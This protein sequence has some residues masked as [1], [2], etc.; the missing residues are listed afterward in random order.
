MNNGDKVEFVINFLSSIDFFLGQ[1]LMNL[2]CGVCSNEPPIACQDV[3]HCI[4][5]ID[6][7]VTE[8]FFY[9]FDV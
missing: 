3:V 1:F 2:T 5:P 7:Q 4:E 9:C 8:K 6:K